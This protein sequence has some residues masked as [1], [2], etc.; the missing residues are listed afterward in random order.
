MQFQTVHG[1][2][3][4]REGELSLVPCTAD[5]VKLDLGQLTPEAGAAALAA[6]ERAVA[7]WK[8][9]LVDVLVT[10]PI[11]KENIQGDKF[12]FPGHTE[13]IQARTGK[14]EGSALMILMKVEEE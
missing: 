10:A 2:A 12:H 5:E 1:P 8:A 6:L 13:Y 9:G 7:D 14:P 3:D 4:A 11:N